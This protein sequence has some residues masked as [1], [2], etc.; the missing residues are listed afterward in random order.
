MDRE[1]ESIGVVKSESSSANRH[2]QDE[3]K[4]GWSSIQNPVKM[5]KK[6]QTDMFL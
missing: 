1:G 4:N 6:L 2:R 5:K 3:F